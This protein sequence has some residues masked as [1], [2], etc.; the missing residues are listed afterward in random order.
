VLLFSNAQN[1]TLGILS[2][3]VCP[4][5]FDHNWPDAQ[6]FK[7][8]YFYF[9]QKGKQKIALFYELG[10]FDSKQDCS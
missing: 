8:T 7:P 3:G 4:E 6:L 2:L 10:L 9:L 5:H 1:S